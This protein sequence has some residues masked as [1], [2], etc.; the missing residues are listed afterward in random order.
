M[1]NLTSISQPGRVFHYTNQ[2]GLIGIVE[3]KSIWAT[4]ILH[5][6]DSAEFWYA[7]QIV[8]Q[9]VDNLTTQQHLDDILRQQLLGMFR[10]QP[11]ANVFICSFSAHPRQLSQF[12]A[13]GSV[14]SAFSL[15]FD[16]FG[17]IKR[18]KEQG[19]E[20]GHCLYDRKEQEAEIARIL[21]EAVTDFDNRLAQ[22]IDHS[23]AANQSATQFHER[24]LAIAPR[25]KNPTFSEEQE[26]RMM[27][28][29]Q[30]ITKAVHFRKGKI[31]IVPYLNFSLADES[32]QLNIPEVYYGP[33]TYEGLT[34]FSVRALFKMNNVIGD[35][36]PSDITLRDS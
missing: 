13:Y 30:S 33:T 28:T 27:C 7:A 16:T 5:L 36:H 10:L 34:A 9:L 4:S 17:L 14:G 19:F 15:G 23:I 11:I 2:E 31:T 1:E 25:I 3:S 21:H 20:F 26:W 24:F 18:G 8:R 12:R 35:V 22:S 29:L 32:G 6:N